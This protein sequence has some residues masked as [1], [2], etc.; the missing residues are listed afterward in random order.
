MNDP[1]ILAVRPA[2]SGA[3]RTIAYVDA[4]LDGLRLFNLK[5]ADGPNG[6]RIYAPSAF[7]C[8]VATFTP[9]LAS[10]LIHL[11]SKALG[12]IVPHDRTCNAA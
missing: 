4:Q 8:S 12:D 1:A 3:G 10:K 11:A 7:G 9:E 2:P 6:R 5:L